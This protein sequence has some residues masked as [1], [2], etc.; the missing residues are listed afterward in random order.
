MATEAEEL[1]LTVTLVDN[2]SAGLRNLQQQMPAME[3]PP[4][5]KPF[6]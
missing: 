2:A 6:G 1:R 5:A 3:P 4:R